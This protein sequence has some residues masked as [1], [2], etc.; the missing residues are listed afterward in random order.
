MGTPFK[1]KASIGLKFSDTVDM[2]TICKTIF[3]KLH[4]KY[5]DIVGFQ[6]CKWD[7]PYCNEVMTSTWQRNVT[8]TACVSTKPWQRRT[9]FFMHKLLCRSVIV[10]IVLYSE[11]TGSYCLLY[12]HRWS[13]YSIICHFK[14]NHMWKLL[15]STQWI[16]NIIPYRE[17]QYLLKIILKI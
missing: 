14:C 5:D 16:L 7:S 15:M 12:S 9:R 11:S 1:R 4:I 13:E 17:F 10:N 3:G 2:N 8:F 6:E